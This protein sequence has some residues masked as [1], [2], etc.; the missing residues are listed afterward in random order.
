MIA[1]RLLAWRTPFCETDWL[2]APFVG[3]ALIVIV[4]QNGFY[5]D[6]PLRLTGWPFLALTFGAAVPLALIAGVRDVL[7]S[8]PVG[9]YGVALAAYLWQGA[10]LLVL[11]SE[12]YLGRAWQDQFNYTS[13]AEFVV[14]YGYSQRAAP[15]ML[16]F[17][18]PATRFTDTRL[19]Q[20]T[21]QGLFALAAGH[22]TRELFGPTILWSI[23][24]VALAVFA[25]MSA[26]G[27]SRRVALLT[28][29]V[30]AV[31]PSLAYIHLESFLSQALGGAY[32]LYFLTV[33][34]RAARTAQIVAYVKASLILA[35]LCAVYLELLPLAAAC[36]GVLLVWNLWNRQHA[37]WPA[38]ASLLLLASP[39]VFNMAHGF[40]GLVEFVTAPILGHIYPWAYDVEGL[41]RLWIGDTVNTPVVQGS[42]AAL[43]LAIILTVAAYLGLLLH[44][45]V[46]LSRLRGAADRMRSTL[47][48]GL[49][50]L[51]IAAAPWAVR[52][53]DRQHPYQFYKL[54]LTTSPLLVCG[55]VLLLWMWG[56]TRGHP[57]A[58]L[59]SLLVCIGIGAASSTMTMALASTQWSRTTG[60][61]PRHFTMWTLAPEYDLAR[62]RLE[63]MQ[64]KDLV[65]CVSEEHGGY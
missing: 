17:L 38:V 54:L 31:L 42:G 10:G 13:L 60:V 24:L 30:A 7:R 27:V 15:G 55:L 49:L 16:P 2:D 18:Q 6:L 11:G 32:L 52:L 25:L 36:I 40:G 8:F 28:A 4:L 21:L 62:R 20:S 5:A 9:P 48:L 46:A 53:L 3:A 33:C 58:V 41:E 64:G 34:D 65:L 51:G 44:P 57:R 39:F 29:A 1:C 59:V 47:V 23:F 37:R 43:A 35:G 26:A 14:T 61:P 12:R 56:Y 50:M 22:P 19:G 45:M 63:A